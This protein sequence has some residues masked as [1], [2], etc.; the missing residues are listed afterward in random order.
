MR[1]TAILF[2]DL[3]RFK[4]VNDTQGHAAGDD[5]LR[6]V[7]EQLTAIVRPHDTVARIGGDEFVVLAANVESHAHA[8]DIGSPA[9][10]IELNHRSGDA[11]RVGASVGIS[12]SI[13]G[14]GPPE[15]LLNEADKAMYQAKALGR[16]RVEVFDAALGRLVQR[17]MNAQR[18][19]QSALDE[20]RV[21][22]YYQPV[23]DLSSG[24]VVG[25]EAL[26]RIAENDGSIVPPLDFISVAEE[27]GLVVPLGTHVLAMACEEVGHWHPDNVPVA[28]L[29]IAVN[30]SARQFEPGDLASVV[31]EKLEQTGLDPSCLHL[32]LTETAIIDLRPDILRQLGNDQRTRCG[33]RSRRLRHRLRVAHSS[34]H[35]CR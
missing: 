34:A 11:D 17:R 4:Q 30:L 29:T 12:V 24:L 28:P 18:R 13:G 7:A 21:I 14:R 15:I 6:T 33:D 2:V 1:C 9:G 3:D 20:G 16:G 32:E 8:I 22:V 23:I 31:H 10:R 5:V 25:F 19:L 26:A 35:A 27:S